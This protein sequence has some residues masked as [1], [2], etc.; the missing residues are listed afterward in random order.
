MNSSSSAFVPHYNENKTNNKILKQT[1]MEKKIRRK[2][3]K[4]QNNNLNTKDTTLA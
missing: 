4:K 3:W 1:K 2:A